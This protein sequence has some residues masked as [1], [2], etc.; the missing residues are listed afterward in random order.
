MIYTTVWLIGGGGS[1]ILNGPP[2]RTCLHLPE[3][4]CPDVPVGFT[5]RLQ[6]SHL[7][8]PGWHNW[9]CSSEEI[10]DGS[11]CLVCRQ[12]ATEYI[13]VS[14]D[15]IT[16]NRGPACEVHRRAIMAG[17]E[18]WWDLIELAREADSE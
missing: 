16:A 13:Q 10:N 8:T 3:S 15:G 1:P 5:A 2:G 9:T 12:P 17:D 7:D 11:T 4:L 14:I 18:D 6:Y